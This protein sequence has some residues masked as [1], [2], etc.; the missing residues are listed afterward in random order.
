MNE[1]SKRRLLPLRYVALIEISAYLSI[2]LISVCFAE[3]GLLTLSGCIWLT[4]LLLAALLFLSWIRFDGGRHPCFLFLGMLLI[5]QGGRLIGYIFGVTPSPMM[6]VAETAS[7]IGVR[8]ESAQ[9]TLLLIC[10]SAICVY[11][12]C[13]LNYKQALFRPGRELLWVPALNVIIVITTPFSLYK[14][15]Q[16]LLFIR[17]H[18]GYLAVY[19]DSAALLQSAGTVARAISLIN[20]TAIMVAYVLERRPRRL[21]IILILF[22]ALST[23]DLLIGFRGKFFTEIVTL[24]FIHNLKT[25][26]RFRLPR[27]IIAGVFISL[28][29]ILASAFREESALVMLSPVG[30]VAQQGISLNVT[31]AAVEFRH[32]FKQYGPGY[33]WGGFMNGFVAQ[34]SEPG[35]SWSADLSNFLNSRAA[36][37]GF[38]TAS[39]Y[40]AELFL[41]GGI[42]AVIIGSLAI[43]Y[44]C[45]F[46]HRCS[47]RAWGA[48]VVAFVLPSLIYLPRLELLNPLAVLIKSF[49]SIVVIAGFVLVWNS[50]I[51]LL[52]SAYRHPAWRSNS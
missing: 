45:N 6:I 1:S 49:V 18:G 50:G 9:I 51:V 17:A 38:G 28:V 34:G 23:L 43:G 25:G 20:V 29:A 4:S 37:L 35:T 42:T 27:L 48:V 52:R 41:F 22:L 24:W 31:E 11:L 30:F 44:C 7:P 15:L 32:D 46:L 16:Y 8:L 19:T 3:I 33:I 21:K 12:P 10:L 13:R 26:Q 36:A 39:S 2:V 14:N 40:L 5:F 47:S